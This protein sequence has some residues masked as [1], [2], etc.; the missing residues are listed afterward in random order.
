MIKRI[1]VNMH[2]IRHN[3]KHKDKKPVITV[4]TS[5]SNTYGDEVLTIAKNRSTAPAATWE[6]EEHTTYTTD[7]SWENELIH[8]FNAIHQ[9]SPILTGSSADALKLMTLMDNIYAHQKEGV[10]T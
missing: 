3:N 10:L 1:H 7:K 2:H 6:D 9:N 4:K 5:K 8:F